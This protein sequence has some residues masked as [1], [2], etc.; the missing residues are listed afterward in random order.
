MVSIGIYISYDA[1]ILAGQLR[2]S[3]LKPDTLYKFILI[4]SNQA[5]DVV[6]RQTVT[7]RTQTTQTT[8]TPTPTPTAASALPVPR[9]TAQA[10]ADA[11]DLRW[12]EVSGAVRYE[13]MVWWDAGTGWQPIGGANLTGTS[14]RHTGVT[15][16][17][18]YYYT[19]RA[20]NAAGE[21]SGWLQEY[22]S[23]TVSQ[24][25][26][27]GGTSTVTPTPTATAAGLSTPALTA[28]TTE[29]GVALS[30][31]AVQDAVRY[32]LMVWWDAGTDWQPIG[33]ASLTGTSYTHTTVTAGTKYYYTIRAVNA[34]GGTSAWLLQYA[35]AVP[36]R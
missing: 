27:A 4:F 19:I 28:A 29:G 13:L 31:G 20:V 17:T 14:Y 24:E 15:A 33:G 21:T 2:A 22:A 11:I 30:W 8:A 25:V 9:L 3:H 6:R 1:G 7:E 26:P 12:T 23:A 18:T 36:S 34:A 35:T 32:E 5:G 10:G 16:G